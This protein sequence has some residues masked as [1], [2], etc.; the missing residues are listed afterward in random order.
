VCFSQEMRA[1]SR[2]LK[3]FLFHKLYRH[4]RVTHTMD[5]AK[6]VV[7]ELFSIYSE[8]PAAMQGG[9]GQRAD[10]IAGEEGEAVF[11]RGIADYIAGMTD[12]FA[13]R[14]HERLTGQRLLVE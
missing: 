5:L 11:R 8:N 9:L 13:L 6:Q 4:P 3:S 2:V 10:A 12:R 14:E 1:Q 7:R